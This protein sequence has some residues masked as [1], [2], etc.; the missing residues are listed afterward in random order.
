MPLA[1]LFGFMKK[2]TIPGFDWCY[3][4]LKFTDLV[5]IGL[6]DVDRGEKNMLRQNNI[7]AYSM[8]DVTGKGIG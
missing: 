8:D 5:Y 3:P 2:G 1:P 7:K 4:N 6:R